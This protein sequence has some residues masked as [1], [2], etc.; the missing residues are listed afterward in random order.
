MNKFKNAL[1]ILFLFTLTMTYAGW[2]E[3]TVHLKSGEILTGWI[4]L[5]AAKENFTRISRSQSILFRST[6]KGEKVKYDHDQVKFVQPNE[7]VRHVYIPIKSRHALCKEYISEGKVKLYAKWV[8]KTRTNPNAYNMDGAMSSKALANPNG[9]INEFEYDE[10][11]LWFEG[12][13]KAVKYFD[14]RGE[15]KFRKVSIEFFKNCPILVKDL[16][17]KKYR[18]DQIKDVV[19]AYNDCF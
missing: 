1:C 16:Q 6:K 7:S 4:K 2:E 14:T 8:E 15:K 9:Y 3:G 12:E 5:P 13:K 17:D 11:F 18:K 10:Y 19:K